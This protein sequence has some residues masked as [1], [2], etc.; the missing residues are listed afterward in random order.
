MQ[1]T[2]QQKKYAIWGGAIA[3][4]YFFG[5]GMMRSCRNPQMT[6]AQ[7]AAIQRQALQQEAAQT[8]ARQQAAAN[9]GAEVAAGNVIQSPGDFAGKWLGRAMVA[10][11][12]TTLTLEIRLDET[13]KFMAYPALTR[14][15]MP[16]VYTT[17]KPDASPQ[18][19]LMGLARTNPFTAILKGESDGK[20]SIAF[21]V[22]KITTPDPMGC[23]WTSAV[24]T[25]FGSKGVTLGWND[26]CGGG[27]LLLERQPL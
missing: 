9:R 24:V 14:I 2:E 13:G 16:S 10:N 5:P 1:L 3:A 4:L 23:R 11:A 21:Q 26:N 27:S 18:S 7:R 19:Y 25:P 22:D 17:G 8:V 20:G 6:P 12:L 15:Q